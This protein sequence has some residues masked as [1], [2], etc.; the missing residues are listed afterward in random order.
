MKSPAWFCTG[1]V[2]TPHSDE[3]TLI[4]H[5][6][7]RAELIYGRDEMGGRYR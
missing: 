4:L 2:G 1:S 5:G 7:V 6:D 3:A